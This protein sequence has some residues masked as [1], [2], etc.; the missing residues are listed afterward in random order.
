MV[1]NSSYK[2]LYLS[3]SLTKTAT[4]GRKSKARNH[5]AKNFIKE[6][7]VLRFDYKK[8]SLSSR[9]LEAIRVKDFDIKTFREIVL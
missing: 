7:N 2:A 5:Y 3:D 9:L 4:L 1:K 6:S 8:D